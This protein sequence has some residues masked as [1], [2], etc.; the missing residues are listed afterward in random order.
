MTAQISDTIQFNRENYSLIGYTGR[1]LFH[2]SSVGIRPD[3]VTTACYQGYYCTYDLTDTALYLQQVTV[4]SFCEGLPTLNGVSALPVTKNICRRDEVGKFRNETTTS[5][6][7]YA[8]SDVGLLVPYTGKFRLAR[9]FLP[10]FHI[11]MGFQKASAFRVVLDITLF[12]GN[13]ASINDRSADM[14]K[15]RGKFKKDY[16][17]GDIT[18]TIENAFSLGMD[19]E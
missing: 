1:G 17:S 16:E 19:I 8:Y 15:I 6:S 5:Q 9:D 11:H 18:K 2:P 4:Y 3:Q 13:V 14:E 7:E 10:E 12:Q